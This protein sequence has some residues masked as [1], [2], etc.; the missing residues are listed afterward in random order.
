[1]RSISRGLTTPAEQLCLGVFV[2]DTTKLSNGTHMM[3]WVVTDTGGAREGIGSRYF[4][5]QNSTASVVTSRV[6]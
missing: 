4:V 1:M 2:L 5:V 6:P 3:Q